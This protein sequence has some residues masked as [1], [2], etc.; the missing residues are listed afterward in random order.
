MS[1]TEQVDRER[2]LFRLLSKSARKGGPA[3]LQAAAARTGVP[4]GDLAALAAAMQERICTAYPD[5]PPLCDLLGLAEPDA[6]SAAKA[7]DWVAVGVYVFG[8]P[9]TKTRSG[10]PES[11]AHRALKEWAA[12]HPAQLSAPPGSRTVTE[13]WFASGDESDVA[14]EA[15]QA[16]LI[17]EVRPSDTELHDLRRALFTLVKLRAV[18]ETEDTLANTPRSVSTVLLTPSAVDPNIAALAASL[19]VKLATAGPL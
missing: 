14:F 10:T 3:E 7:Y 9:P 16:A 8:L 13:R 17:V 2:S 12:N 11:A 18:M 5:A 6:L 1:D 19:G 4:K 15:E